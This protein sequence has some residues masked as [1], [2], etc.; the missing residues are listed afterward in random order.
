MIIEPLVSI[1]IPF[2]N[3]LS[4]LEKA[5]QSVL[6]QS[7]DSFELI[8]IDDGSTES[9]DLLVLCA[10]DRVSYVR[11][12]NKGRS[13]ARNKGMQL[14]KGRYIAFLDADDLFLPSKLEV[15]CRYMDNHTDVALSHTSYQRI[16][17][18][19]KVLSEQHS[20]GYTYSHYT[21][22]MIFCPFATPT[23]M[24]RNEFV[25]KNKL[26]FPEGM[27]VGED[28]YFWVSVAKYGRIDGL[29]H[30][31]TQ[32]RMHGANSSSDVYASIKVKKILMEKV[33][34]PDES[35][36][37]F[38]KRVVTSRLW[39]SISK[40]YYL[41]REWSNAFQCTQS[42]IKS[43]PVRIFIIVLHIGRYFLK[44]LTGRIN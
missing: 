8:I 7:F 16:N 29:D 13:V 37:M 11:Q 14:A 1:V 44:I 39:Q 19:G 12:E 27:H 26:R 6:A 3:G 34:F 43:C 31:L 5:V 22:L 36:G 25:V 4:W 42:A 28:I 30:L 18:E 40:T 38:R 23:V 21:D 10:D 9:V 17:I 24:I 15:Q 32:V 41:K 20:G 2:Y 35:M 33:L